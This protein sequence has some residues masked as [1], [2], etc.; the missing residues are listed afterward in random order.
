[1]AIEAKITFKSIM[2]IDWIGMPTFQFIPEAI[3]LLGT[4][5]WSSA[6]NESD[7]EM[8]LGRILCDQ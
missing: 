4:L 2:L 3:R 7:I 5:E 1:M 8:A 6:A